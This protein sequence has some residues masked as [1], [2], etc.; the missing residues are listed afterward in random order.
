MTVI[1][2]HDVGM[3]ETLADESLSPELRHHLRIPGP[4]LSQNFD[5]DHAPVSNRFAAIHSSEAARHIL[6]ELHAPQHHAV[7]VSCSQATFLKRSD[8]L[9]PS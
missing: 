9:L 8:Q 1:D 7:R 5:A 3:F 4:P 2:R 6:H